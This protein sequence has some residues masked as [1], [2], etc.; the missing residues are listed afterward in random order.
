M[1][2]K[3]TTP[4]NALNVF[5]TNA[6][7]LLYQYIYN[8]LCKLGEECIVKIRDRDETSSWLDHTGNLRSS[9]G[10]AIYSSGKKLIQSRF[11]VVKGGSEGKQKGESYVDSLASEYA[12][13]FALV[14]VAAM[15]YAE[16]VERLENKDVLDSTRIW[17]EG[18]VQQKIDRAVDE[19]IKV[20]NSW[21][22]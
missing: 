3:R 17:A 1:A 11:N 19:A 14:V 10:Y 6:H 13:T 15:D 9:I 8:A 5:F 4:E 2:I 18:V 7:K 12:N 21:T 16:F 20:I 22:I